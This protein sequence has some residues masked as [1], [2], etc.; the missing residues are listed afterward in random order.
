MS[1]GRGFAGPKRR[2]LSPLATAPRFMGSATRFIGPCYF[3]AHNARYV[4][5][6][7]MKSTPVRCR[8][9]AAPR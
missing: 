6:K 7:P 5:V 3:R 4:V 9:V 2:Q 1:A 8:Y